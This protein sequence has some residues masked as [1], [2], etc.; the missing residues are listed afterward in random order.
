MELKLEVVVIPVADVDRALAFYTGIGFRQ[1]ADFR[2]DRGLRVV[3]VTPPGSEASIIFGEQLTTAAPGS[4]QGLHLVTADVA[5]AR[6][7]LADLGVEISEL[8]HDADGIFHWAGEQNR[9]PGAHP[10]TD[11]YGTFASFADPDGN[12]WTI[13]QVVTRAPGR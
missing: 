11:S 4:V 2:T 9:L 1:D 10:D 8:W 6:R 3:Q 7:E 12:S 5:G 13:Q